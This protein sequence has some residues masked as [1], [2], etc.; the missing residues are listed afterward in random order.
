MAVSPE[1]DDGE[2]CNLGCHCCS[3]LLDFGQIPV[4]I[5]G[6]LVGGLETVIVAVKV[7]KKYAQKSYCKKGF[8]ILSNVTHIGMHY[9]SISWFCS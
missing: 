7:Q 1:K 2:T 3:F 8:T 6:C 9:K 5:C 4:L